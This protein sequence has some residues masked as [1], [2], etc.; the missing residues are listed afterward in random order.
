MF[1]S[2]WYCSPAMNSKASRLSSSTYQRL[3]LFLCFLA[4]ISLGLPDGLLGVAWPS[5]S[6]FFGVP[7]SN[8]A[9][10]QVAFT[11]G[12]LLS[13]TNAGRLTR[14]LGVGK[15]LIASNL[16][17][18]A[19]MTGYV[20]A[21]RWPV[22]VGATIVLGTA[23][24]AVDAALNAYAAGRFRKEQ[25]TLLHAFYGFGAMLGP[26]IMRRI[27]QRGDP[28][29]RGYLT[30]LVLVGILLI[31]FIL[32]RRF[33][34]RDGSQ[35][36]RTSRRDS[37]G[38]G[39]RSGA[40][41]SRA[42][43]HSVPL[44]TRLVGISL[45]LFYTG[46]EVTV[47]AW[48]FSLFTAGRGTSPGTAALW[49]GIYWGALTG[50]RLFFGFFGSRWKT[51]S[52]VRI[53][54]IALVSGTVMLLQPW[55]APAALVSLPLIGFACAPLFPMFVTLTPH[56]VGDLHA[57]DII[58]LQVAS[59]SL[60]AAVIPGLVGAAVELSSIE[61]AAWVTLLLALLIAGT[62]RKWVS[63]SQFFS[64]GGLGQDGGSG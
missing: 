32:S 64:A 31:L 10:L 14:R 25:V 3:L 63:R 44:S 51:G 4:F 9:V 53:M 55:Y 45:F 27:L 21:G 38:A 15:L 2:C 52:I 18:A 28:W 17:A 43:V 13:S 12:F 57:P 36:P 20:V 47:G 8:L 40:H 26:V 22:F 39:S 50:G 62:Y 60:G 29:Q 41:G 16:S 34:Y 19:A 54:L 61:A 24:G 5:I 58:G 30:T 6:R 42:A 7:I 59:A 11:I 56:V 49:V 46:L 35:A 48:S 23:G 37:A 33:W 1:E